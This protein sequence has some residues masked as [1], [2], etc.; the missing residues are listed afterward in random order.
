MVILLGILA[1][2]FVMSKEP[3]ISRNSRNNWILSCLVGLALLPSPLFYAFGWK[4][5]LAYRCLDMAGFVG[6]DAVY[7][8]KC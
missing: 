6:G 2:L 4:Q 8:V 3:V 1:F 5:G 7:I